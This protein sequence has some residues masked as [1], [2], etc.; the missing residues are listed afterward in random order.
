[1]EKKVVIELQNVKRQVTVAANESNMTVG[2]ATSSGATTIL[3]SSG[4]TAAEG[5][6]AAYTYCCLFP[7]QAWGSGST[8]ADFLKIGA[9]GYTTTYRGLNTLKLVE[10]GG[11]VK[12]GRLIRPCVAQADLVF[13]KNALVVL[14][15]GV[16]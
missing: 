8:P 12:A 5:K 4:E 16:P 13:L 14:P 1:M 2:T 9:D 7:V 11:K 10:I 6:A 3:L 15:H